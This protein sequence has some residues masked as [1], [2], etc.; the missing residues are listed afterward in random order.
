MPKPLAE[1]GATFAAI[2]K[3]HGGVAPATGAPD[4]IDRQSARPA[5]QALI[6]PAAAQTIAPPKD[7]PPA[8]LVAGYD[9]A[10]QCA[11]AHPRFGHGRQLHA[12]AP[13]AR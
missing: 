2:V 8:F 3:E 10:A 11:P 7:A 13:P 9:D 5:F 4:P 12:G 6:Y 1:R